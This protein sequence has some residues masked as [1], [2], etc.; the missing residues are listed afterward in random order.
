MII[1]GYKAFNKDRTSRYNTP[2]EEGKIYQVNGPLKFGNSGNGIHFCKRLEDTLRYFPAMEEE[3]AIAQ[4]TGI[5]EI[6]EY[7]DDYYGYYDMYAARKL[8]IDKFLERDEIIEMFLSL[9]D[10]RVKRFVSGFKLTE[11]EIKMFKETFQTEEK[12]LK[13]I[14]YYQENERDVYAKS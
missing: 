11:E 5:G 4:V 13:A 12:V 2:Y 14:A 10:D 7:Y 3:I 6:V 9:H 1:K 8:K